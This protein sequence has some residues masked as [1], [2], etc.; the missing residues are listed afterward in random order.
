LKLNFKI[1]QQDRDDI[2]NIMLQREHEEMPNVSHMEKHWDKMQ[3]LLLPNTIVAKNNFLKNIIGYGIAAVL[4]TVLLVFVNNYSSKKEASVAIKKNVETLAPINVLIDTTLLKQKINN[5]ALVK[6][7][8]APKNNTQI[9]VLHV[10]A[11]SASL[12]TVV[13]DTSVFK[14]MASKIDST[15]KLEH[16]VQEANQ[17]LLSNFISSIQKRGERFTINNFRDTTIKAAEGTVFFIPMGSF[18]TKDSVVFEVKEYYKYSDMVANGLTTMADDKQLISGGMLSL[19]ATANGKEIAMNPAKEIRVFIPNLT[20]KDSMEIFEGKKRETIDSNFKEGAMIAQNNINWQ[21]SKVRIDSAV[22]KMYLRAIDLTD[23]EI[24]YKITNNGKAKAIFFKAKNSKINKS[25]LLKMIKE[26]HG[27]YYDIIKLRNLSWPATAFG[28]T[29]ITPYLH[30]DYTGIGD[31]SDYSP[32]MIEIYKLKIIDTVYKVARWINKGYVTTNRPSFP[33][34]TLNLIGEK[35]SIG[36]NKLGWINCDKFY[37][38]PGRKSNVTVDLKD[39]AFSYITYMVFD[40]YKSIM[41]G[42]ENGNMVVF[43]NV[44]IGEPV[45]IVS[46]GIK[47]GKIIAAMKNTITSINLIHDLPFEQTSGKD[48]KASLVNLD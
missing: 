40:K 38:Y 25:E 39:S 15:N 20:A 42:Y 7:N 12:F 11:K 35:Y 16:I 26:K 4:I 36:I 37:N 32:R 3:Q 31:T 9:T 6:N 47:N 21:L 48:F 17:Q 34:N 1:M 29:S 30:D 41:Q 28:Y 14:D 10:K 24:I 5:K 33:I 43:P 13:N 45:K 8:S 2:E 22:I 27:N 23:D 44:P 18:N 46:I 19:T